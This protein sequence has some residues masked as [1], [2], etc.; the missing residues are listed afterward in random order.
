MN[1]R[2]PLLLS[3]LAP[4]GVYLGQ[5]VTRLPV[6]SYLAISPWPAAG[7]VTGCR[8]YVSVALSL[9]SPPLAVSQH[10]ALWSSDFPRP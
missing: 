3:G 2:L 10:L 4:D 8:W 5:P 7:R 6:S 1:S 9:G